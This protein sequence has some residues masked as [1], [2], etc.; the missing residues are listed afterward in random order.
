MYE[1][2]YYQIESFE[3][4]NWW[5]RAR[6][7]LLDKILKSLNTLFHNTLDAGCGVG[8]NFEVLTK[9]SKNVYGIDISDDAIELCSCKNYRKLTKM[10]LLDFKLDVEFDLVACMDVLE[11][12]DDDMEAVKNLS[13]HIRTNG[14]L[15]VSVPAHRFLWNDNDRFGG[16]LRRYALN[17]VRRIVNANNLTILKLS[18][19]NQFMFVPSSIYCI[20]CLLRKERRLKNNLTLIPNVFNEVLYKILKAENRLFIKFGLLEGVSIFCICQK[21]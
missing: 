6:R 5:Y 4:N 12:V 20:V 8:S 13:S 15:I 2:N 3:K 16:H 18:Y 7:D 21:Q 1:D 14:I 17:D 9:Y 10:S 19:W 11:H